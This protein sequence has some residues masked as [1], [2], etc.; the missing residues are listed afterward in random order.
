MICRMWHGITPRAKADAYTDFL[1][2]RAIPDYRSVPGNLSVAVLR[3][4]ESERTHFMT[5]THWE[6]EDSIRAFAG[7]DLLKAK[8]FPEDRDFLLA[9]EPEVQHF[10]VT[11]FAEAG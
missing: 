5:V 6:S 10:V 3:R 7:E 2:Q 8:Y 1:E 11:A 9:F 4:D